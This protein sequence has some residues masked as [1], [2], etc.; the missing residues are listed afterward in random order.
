MQSCV[1]IVSFAVIESRGCGE[2]KVY[3]GLDFAGCVLLKRR[4]LS[5]LCSASLKL[6]SLST[7]LTSV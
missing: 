3:S 5:D 4:K 2:H 6:R 7:T 1:Y